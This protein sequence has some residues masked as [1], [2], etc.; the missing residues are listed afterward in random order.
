MWPQIWEVWICVS[1]PG[2][3]ISLGTTALWRKTDDRNHVKL[4]IA[5]WWLGGVSLL[6]SPQIGKCSRRGVSMWVSASAM[7]FERVWPLWFV[8]FK[9]V[10]VC[11]V[12]IVERILHWRLGGVSLLKLPQIGKC[13]ARGVSVWVS[14][15]AM[16][17]ERVWPSW[18]VRF[19][20][21]FFLFSPLLGLLR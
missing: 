10:F 1:A 4:L 17:F 21:V 16:W 5:N 20:I 15:S 7:W 18:F 14:A 9:I 13:S 3:L 6:K 2:S 8:R 11:F 12:Y 19:K